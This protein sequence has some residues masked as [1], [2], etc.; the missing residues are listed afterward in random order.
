MLRGN[1]LKVVLYRPL[2][3]HNSGA[4][5]RTCAMLGAELHLVKPLGFE[6]PNKDLRRASM[7]YIDDTT[8]RVHES[9]QAFTS[10]LE[11]DVGVWLFTDGA[12]DE[13]TNVR[14]GPD[15]YL[16][17]GR[18]NDGIPQEILREHRTLSIPMRGARGQPRTDHRFHSLNVSVSAAIGLSEALR[19]LHSE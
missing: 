18:E 15:D 1:V 10:T 11:S 16:V 19:Q 12:Q 4:I 2:N 3:P 7:D 13:Y 14:Y 8:V 17:F 9:W 6:L 5:A